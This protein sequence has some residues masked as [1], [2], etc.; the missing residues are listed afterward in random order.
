MKK[1][2]RKCEKSDFK[3]KGLEEKFSRFSLAVN[4]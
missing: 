1:V 4:S 3:N 2:E